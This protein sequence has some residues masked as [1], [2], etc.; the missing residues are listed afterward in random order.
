[1]KAL[2]ADSVVS[3]SLLGGL[4]APTKRTFQ[5]GLGA[6]VTAAMTAITNQVMIAITRKASGTFDVRMIPEAD[7]QSVRDGFGLDS[8]GGVALKISSE[9]P[10]GGTRRFAYEGQST[11]G[12]G[13]LSGPLTAGIY[14]LEDFL[15]GLADGGFNDDLVAIGSP[16]ESWENGHILVIDQANGFLYLSEDGEEMYVAVNQSVV[17]PELTLVANEAKWE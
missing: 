1:M 14:S 9:L 6:A 11:G 17:E 5:G 4:F 8:T 10:A 7:W 16:R 13:P 3:S 12:A 15:N 2:T